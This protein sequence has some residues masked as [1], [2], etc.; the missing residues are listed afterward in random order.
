MVLGAGRDPSVV[1]RPQPL[2]R[3]RIHASKQHVPRRDLGD[4]LGL[5]LPKAANVVFLRVLPGGRGPPLHGVYHP[6]HG[7]GLPLRA[8]YGSLS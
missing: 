1:I 2:R 5:R 6:P 8:T 3:P 4:G 7:E